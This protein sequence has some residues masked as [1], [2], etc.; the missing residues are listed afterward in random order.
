ML[1]AAALAEIV[2]F[3][4]LLVTWVRKVRRTATVTEPHNLVARATA[5][6]TTIM[7]MTT[8]RDSLVVLLVAGYH[9]TA[10][11]NYQHGQ[12]DAPDV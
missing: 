4:L 6:A 9:P 10:P 11:K 8:P 3:T 7:D 2:M 5:A 12:F 1:G